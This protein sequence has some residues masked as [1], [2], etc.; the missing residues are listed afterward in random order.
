[1]SVNINFNKA[2]CLIEAVDDLRFPVIQYLVEKKEFNPNVKNQRGFSVVHYLCGIE[3]IQFAERTLA[4]LFQH[5]ANVNEPTLHERFT[6]LHI[7][8]MNDRVSIAKIL[9]KQGADKKFLDADGNPP[10]FYAINNR[11][12]TT[13]KVIRNYIL[14]EKAAQARKQNA[15]DLLQSAQLNSLSSGSN[16]SGNLL[17][18][19]L[20]VADANNVSDALTPSRIIYNFDH[21]SPYNIG[22]THRRNYSMP[23]PLFPQETAN[24]ENVNIFELT[25]ENLAQFSKSVR[26]SGRFEMFQQWQENVEDHK[27]RPSVLN[28]IIRECN[29]FLGE[30]H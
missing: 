8:A 13:I 7:A 17:N 2:I 9:I 1:M 18:T 22:I 11:C 6:P 3:Y 16:R 14:H 20:V 4:Y 24:T 12:W 29:D 15:R 23:R 30:F 10:I 21:L 5:G 26:E 27:K 25:E 19:N 28:S